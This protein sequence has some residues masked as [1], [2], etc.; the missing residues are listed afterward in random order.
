MASSIKRTIALVVAVSVLALSGPAGAAEPGLAFPESEMMYGCD[1]TELLG[2]WMAAHYYQDDRQLAYIQSQGCR[3]IAGR[4]FSIVW[5]RGEIAAV[6]VYE[7][8][9]S[10]VLYTLAFHVSVALKLRGAE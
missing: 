5:R 6:R 2:E 9:G 7:G 8:D 1:S 10:M 3:N 4:S